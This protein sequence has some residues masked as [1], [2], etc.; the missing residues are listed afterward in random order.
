MTKPGDQ[1][2]WQELETGFV[3]LEPGSA[4]DYKT[5]DWKSEHPVWNE[6][7]CIKCGLCYTFCPDMA[8]CQKSTGYF[9]GDYDYCK[10]C[11]ICSQ[12][13]PTGAISMVEGKE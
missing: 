4:R 11:G 1:W 3:I 13:C 7:L 6:S 10:G 8:V 2:K 12:E 5:G 9:A